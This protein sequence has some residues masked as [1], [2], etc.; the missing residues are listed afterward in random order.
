[1]TGEM[2]HGPLPSF[3]GPIYKLG[4]SPYTRASDYTHVALLDTR[5]KDL[6]T[7]PSAILEEMKIHCAHYQRQPYVL[8]VTPETL[9]QAGVD[10]ENFDLMRPLG[11]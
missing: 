1:M 4:H 7:D 9:R 5:T 11:H 6:N 10:S 2:I 3:Y 8:E